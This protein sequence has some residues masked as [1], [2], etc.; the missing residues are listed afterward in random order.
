MRFFNLLSALAVIAFIGLGLLAGCG[1][2]EE[3]K[4][5]TQVAAKVNGAEITVHQINF[6]LARSGNVPP[7]QAKAAAEQVLE[8]L[9]DQQILVQKAMEK[10]LDRDPRV[11]QMIEAAKQQ[12]LAQAYLELESSPVTSSPNDVKD[13]YAKHPELFEKRRIYRYQQIAVKQNSELQ[14]KLQEQMS[15]AKNLN[16]IALWLKDQGVQFGAAEVATR[17]A[18]QLPLEWLPVFQTLSNGKIAIVEQQGAWLITQLLGSQ[19]KPL[20]EKQATPYIQQYLLNQK[21]IEFVGKEIKDMRAQAKVEYIGDF[22]PPTKPAADAPA[23]TQKQTA[24]KED[25]AKPKQDTS[26]IEKGLSGLK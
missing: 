25:E 15:K 14:S 5:S 17:P 11:M 3:K 2:G 18:E 19:E 22:A 4:T 8:K 10:K 23:S 7:E 24:S 20:D 12:I 9:V 6:A 21:R 16:D 26:F 1:K 13:F